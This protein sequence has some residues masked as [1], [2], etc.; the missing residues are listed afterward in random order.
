MSQGISHLA[1]L[2][3]NHTSTCLGRRFSCLANASFCFCTQSIHHKTTPQSTTY[4]PDC[5]SCKKTK[6]PY[7]KTII[8]QNVPGWEC[9]APWKFLQGWET[10]PWWGVA[11]FWRR[12]RPHF[13][14]LRRRFLRRRESRSLCLPPRPPLLPVP[15]SRS[16]SRLCSIS[17]CSET[18]RRFPHSN[19][20]PPPQQRRVSGSRRAPGGT[21]C[22]RSSDLRAKKEFSYWNG[23]LVN[24]GLRFVHFRKCTMI[25][26]SLELEFPRLLVLVCLA[27]QNKFF[28]VCKWV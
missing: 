15:L 16:S 19:P 1:L 23:S 28:Y 5:Q 20:P 22:R 17:C 27:L 7:Q 3:W 8:T 6:I 25:M 11:S 14:R 4:L 10:G 21:T 12:H 9:C 18:T 24:K 26:I 13:R 2:F